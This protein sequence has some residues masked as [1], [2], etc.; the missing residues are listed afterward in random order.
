[1]KKLILF[2]VVVTSF[3]GCKE[4]QK[5][6]ENFDFGSIEHG[7]YSNNY[8]KFILP[9]DES[10][11]IQS[12]EQMNET[13]QIGA[14]LITNDTI[15]AAV[16]ATEVNNA[17]LFAAYRYPLA[18]AIEYNYSIIVVAENTKMF[19]NVKR[20][21]DYLDEAKKLMV[22]TAVD[23]EFE[24]DYTSTTIGDQTFDIMYVSGGYMGNY[25]KQEYMTTILNGFSFSI[26]LSYDTDNQRQS[27]QKLLDGMTFNRSKS[28]KKS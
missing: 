20:G 1:L 9:F 19:P 27:L 12:L 23:Y 8:F 14:D 2:L 5:M 15:K 4:E 21:S 17:N 7:V 18:E 10:W 28:K 26:I 25:F 24:E 6:P 13:A 22:Q 3:F 16:K 11:N